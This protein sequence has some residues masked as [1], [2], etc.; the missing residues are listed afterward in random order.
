MNTVQNYAVFTCNDSFDA[1][2]HLT[3][4]D[5]VRHIYRDHGSDYRL[6]PKMLRNRS[7]E[8]GDELPDIQ[9]TAGSGDLVFEVWFKYNRS[10]SWHKSP[11]IAIGKNEEEAEA[12]FLQKS[13]DCTMW[14]N[15]YWIVLDTEQYLTEQAQQDGL[16]V[17]R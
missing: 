3:A 16:G 7:D 10:S 2:T 14:D 5:I 1:E 9:D 4:H 15:S 17:F 12:A 8:E 11:R 13:F 6:E